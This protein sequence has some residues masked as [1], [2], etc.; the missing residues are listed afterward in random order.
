MP[1]PPRLILPRL[2]DDFRAA[3]GASPP[4]YARLALMNDRDGVHGAALASLDCIE[5]GP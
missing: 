4:A 3:F 1:R 2:A 5:A